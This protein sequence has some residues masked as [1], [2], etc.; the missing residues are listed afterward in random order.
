ML[1][2]LGGVGLVFAI[3]GLLFAAFPGFVR[4]RMTEALSLGEGKMRTVGIVSA[5]VGVAIIW[6]VRRQAG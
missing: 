4:S 3:E 2:F 6:A 5:A 1:D